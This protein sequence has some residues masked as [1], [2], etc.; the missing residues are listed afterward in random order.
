MATPIAH[1]ISFEMRHVLGMRC[2]LVFVATLRH[3]AFVAV[4][5]VMI[6]ISVATEVMAAMK[7]WTGTDEDTT[8]KPFRT[9]VARGSAAVRRGVIVPV[10]T[11][12]GQLRC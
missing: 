7:P 6:V 10:R 2:G 3:R 8:G 1:F 9:V 4:F 11:F 5:R 12:R